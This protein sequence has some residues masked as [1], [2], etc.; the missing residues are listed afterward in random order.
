M[1]RPCK[2]IVHDHVPNFP[3]S[4]SHETLIRQ[5]ICELHLQSDVEEGLTKLH[6]LKLSSSPNETLHY[7]PSQIQH[8][9]IV[10]WH[11]CPETQRKFR[12]YLLEGC[13]MTIPGSTQLLSS[14]KTK[15]QRSKRRENEYSSPQNQT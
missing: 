2:P 4:K 13:S 5:W 12:Q 6:H 1:Y 8:S 15:R 10:Q 3:N 7:E 14:F 11:L 9:T